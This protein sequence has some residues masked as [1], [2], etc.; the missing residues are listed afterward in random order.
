[1]HAELSP[2][3]LQTA[4]CETL[5]RAVRDDSKYEIE[6]HEILSNGRNVKYR[7]FIDIYTA[8]KSK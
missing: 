5:R 4:K 7:L 2:E 3:I 6:I 1:M 8:C